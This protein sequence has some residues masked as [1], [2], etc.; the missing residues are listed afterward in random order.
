MLGSGRRENSP[1][2]ESLPRDIA[3]VP[4]LTIDDDFPMEAAQEEFEE[5]YERPFRAN[6]AKT[7]FNAQRGDNDTV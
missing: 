4:P 2:E 3:A 5:N 6:T 1:S 7:L